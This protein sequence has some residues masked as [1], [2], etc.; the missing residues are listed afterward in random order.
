[1]GSIV[2]FRWS[3]GE[4]VKKGGAM[5]GVKRRGWGGVLVCFVFVCLFDRPGHCVKVG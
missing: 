4:G 5:E 1:M 2:P 3:L